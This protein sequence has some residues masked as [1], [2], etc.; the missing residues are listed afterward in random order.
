MRIVQ[1]L[2]IC[3][4]LYSLGVLLA[5][6]VMNVQAGCPI[7]AFDEE[8]KHGGSKKWRWATESRESV[9]RAL[10][11]DARGNPL[12]EPS[13]AEVEKQID[14]QLG[15]N[16][17]TNRLYRTMRTY[18]AAAYPVAILGIVLFAITCFVRRPKWSVG[19]GIAGI[20]L[21]FAILARC[22]YL[23]ILTKGLLNR[24]LN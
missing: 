23:G 7:Q 15:K 8:Y 10:A 5:I 13:P 11:R 4:V 20:A 24:V 14:R 12:P 6:E 2:G 17:A 18:G 22:V 3:C 9:T 19:V 16:L 1:L 21:C